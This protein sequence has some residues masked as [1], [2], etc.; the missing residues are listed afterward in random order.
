MAPPSSRELSVLSVQQ[1]Q[2]YSSASSCSIATP[3]L[4]VATIY[5]NTFSYRLPPIRNIMR[6]SVYGQSITKVFLDVFSLSS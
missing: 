3:I 4:F 1:L 2:L 5:T 6:A